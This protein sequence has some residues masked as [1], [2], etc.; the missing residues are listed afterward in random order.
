MSTAIFCL[1]PAMQNLL[2][3]VK[4]CALTFGIIFSASGNSLIFLLHEIWEGFSEFM[5]ERNSPLGTD[6]FS[7][8]IK[9]PVFTL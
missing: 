4:V 2:V 8:F 6:L 5:I 7:F 9:I 3:L 1:Q